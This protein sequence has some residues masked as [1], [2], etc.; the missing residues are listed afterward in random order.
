MAK[1]ESVPIVYPLLSELPEALLRFGWAHLQAGRPQEAE[2]A[3]RAA[4]LRA[5]RDPE[6]RYRLA[7]ALLA[8]D[9]AAEASLCM[10]DA[11][12]LHARAILAADHPHL[13][14]LADADALWKG[15]QALFEQGQHSLCAALLAPLFDANPD[16]AVLLDRQ[17]LLLAQQGR[18]EEAAAVYEAIIRRQGYAPEAHSHLHLQRIFQQTG[19]QTLFE[20]GERWSRLCEATV[21]ARPA[22]PLTSG[23]RLRIG[24]FSATFNRH[25][26]GYFFLPVLEAHDSD[27][28]EVFCYSQGTIVD[29]VGEAARAKATFRQVKRLSDDEFCDLIEADGI[30]ILVDLWGHSRHHRLMV[31]ARRPAPIQVS[32]L[33][34]INTTG[35]KAFDYVLLPDGYRAPGDQRWFSEE[36]MSLGEI[37][38]P[39]RVIDPVE[40]AAEPPAL[41]RG[42]VTFA[43]AAHPAKIN[44]E[45]ARTW[46]EILKRVPGSVLELRYMLYRDPVVAR[47]MAAQFES[48][49]VPAERLRFPAQV[50]GRAFR[51][52]FNGL[53]LILDPFPYQGM[54]TTMDALSMGVPIVALEGDY[55]ALKVA[56]SA[57]RLCGLGELVADSLEAYVD[58][59][60]ALATDLE[61][62]RAVRR[63]VLP[64]FEAS[65]FRQEA[66]FARRLEAAYHDMA[67][68]HRTRAEA[69]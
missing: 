55:L 33:N 63:K 25:Q 18:T 13:L 28:V 49:G 58:L 69:A 62:L 7:A 43:S 17:A 10:A 67:D 27:A 5:P 66:A 54:T 15:A 53:D 3:F 16:Y 59:A 11:Q 26:L 35:L 61:R 9:K 34:Y 6:A 57:L 47:A 23:R 51:E 8:Q 20:E 60:V 68:L 45:V 42:Y 2:Q 29:D 31:F 40:P 22:R 52:A 44:L 50:T 12:E 37:I 39:Y 24:Y 56:P 30:D 32:Y 65:Q 4:A 21:Q 14:G 48:C 1:L 19:P 41:T 38:A 36:I 64:G 46:A